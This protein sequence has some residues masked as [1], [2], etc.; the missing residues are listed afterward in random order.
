MVEEGGIQGRGGGGG[1]GGF[2]FLLFYGSLFFF[3]E[4]LKMEKADDGIIGIM[5]DGGISSEAGGSVDGR[6]PRGRG[7]NSVGKLGVGKICGRGSVG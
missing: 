2:F 6:G 5:W 4:K 3:N 1:E 7:G